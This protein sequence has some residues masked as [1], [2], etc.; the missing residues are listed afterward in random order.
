MRE[1]TDNQPTLVA[2]KVFKH[3]GEILSGCGRRLDI[4]AWSLNLGVVEQR[5]FWH[6]GFGL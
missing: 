6:F 5:K 4:D 2:E 1:M 3:A